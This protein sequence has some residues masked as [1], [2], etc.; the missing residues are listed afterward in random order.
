MTVRHLRRVL[1][2]APDGVRSWIIATGILA[3]LTGPVLVNVV[4]RD[5]ASPGS[6]V[7]YISS[8]GP[9][10][11]LLGADGIVAIDT[12][13]E[14]ARPG[15][16]IAW[17]ARLC[18][19]SDLT[20]RVESR[21]VQPA[22]DAAPEHAVAWSDQIG[23]HMAHECTDLITPIGIPDGA[24]SGTYQFRRKI[25]VKVG[26]GRLSVERLPPLR[27]EVASGPANAR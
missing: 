21:L 12:P 19:A 5:T 14:R 27:L 4:L 8:Q 9:F 11:A 7:A 25:I 3:A 13:I 18:F 10:R 24:L 20:L 26:S 1:R 2:A 15:D 17:I 16:R 23:R 6:V 22:V